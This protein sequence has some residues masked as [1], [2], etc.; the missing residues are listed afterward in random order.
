MKKICIAF[1]LASALS[2]ASCSLSEESSG[3]SSSSNKSIISASS[4]KKNSYTA[5][6][7]LDMAEKSPMHSDSLEKRAGEDISA[8]AVIAYNNFIKYATIYL[9]DQNFYI[10]DLYSTEDKGAITGYMLKI[11]PEDY[12]DSS[13]DENAVVTLFS[14]VTGS[15]IKGT[16]AGF[17]FSRKWTETLRDEIND[18]YPVYHFSTFTLQADR[19]ILPI[20]RGDETYSLNNIGNEPLTGDWTINL[21]LPAGTEKTEFEKACADILPILKKFSA[22]EVTVLSASINESF[23]K[24]VNEEGFT[25][26]CYYY[27]EEGFDWREIYNVK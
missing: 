3:K 4:E 5:E 10:Y 23:E 17:F 21:I 11:V 8:E 18:K 19:D 22:T 24:F 2:L 25:G 16:L 26:N 6:E 20:E 15:H 14:D 7:L 9:G 1:L 27:I 12:V 13:D